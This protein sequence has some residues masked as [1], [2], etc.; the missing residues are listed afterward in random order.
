MA[1]H[2]VKRHGIGKVKYRN[3]VQSIGTAEIGGAQARYRLVRHRQSLDMNSIGKAMIRVAT[4]E[5]CV[6]KAM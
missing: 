5:E 6:A 3:K 1:W 4:A 2:G